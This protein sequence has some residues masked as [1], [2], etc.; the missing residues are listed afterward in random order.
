MLYYKFN[1]QIKRIIKVIQ[2]CGFSIECRVEL[3]NQKTYYYNIISLPLS[4]FTLFFTL[5]VILK[6]IL[7]QNLMNSSQ[8]FKKQRNERDIFKLFFNLTID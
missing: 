5:Q 1:W 6:I 8:K 2:L 7:K 3:I 4:F